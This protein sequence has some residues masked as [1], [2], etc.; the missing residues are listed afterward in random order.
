MEIYIMYIKSSIKNA[1]GFTLVEI[2]IVVV[3]IGI[4]ALLAL[5]VFQQVRNASLENAILNNLRQVHSSGE[6]YL[7]FNGGTQV[8][9]AQLR[10]VDAG[11]PSPT[12]RWVND[13]QGNSRV[14][15][16][17]YTGLAVSSTGGTLTVTADTVGTVTFEY[18]Q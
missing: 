13:I 11:A 10:T 9:Y 2:M 12:G 15:G 8:T 17:T 18:G 14:D 7:I 3:I 4:L 16:E 1:K 5:P 6:Q